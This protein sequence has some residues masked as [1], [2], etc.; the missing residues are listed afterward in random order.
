MK[1]AVAAAW[2]R[3]DQDAFQHLIF[4]QFIKRERDT[5]LKEY[6]F[7]AGAIVSAD[8]DAQTEASG[9]HAALLVGDQQYS[10]IEAVDSAISWWEV[11]IDKIEEGANS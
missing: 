9:P 1:T 11:E 3:W 4:H 8:A 10:V 7:E 6:R 2:Q 5:I